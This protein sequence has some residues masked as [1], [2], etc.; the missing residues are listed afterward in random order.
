MPTDMVKV[1][2]FTLDEAL[3]L[4]KQ[5][6]TAMFKSGSKRTVGLLG[7]P[8]QQ[9][10]A[11]MNLRM[12]KPI[13]EYQYDPEASKRTVLEEA[14]AQPIRFQG[15][16]Y[17]SLTRF[18]EDFRERYGYSG[19]KY[20]SRYG[21]L[22]GPD[23][24]F[25]ILFNLN[26]PKIRRNDAMVTYQKRLAE[27]ARNVGKGL[28]NPNTGDPEKDAVLVQTG[29]ELVA[30][31][32][33]YKPRSNRWSPQ[34]IGELEMTLASSGV[35]SWDPRIE[36]AM[37]V[38]APSPATAGEI[39]VSALL[40]GPFAGVLTS[41]D[42][43][44]NL[45][46]D[47]LAKMG[48]AAQSS[49]LSPELVEE[50]DNPLDVVGKSFANTVRGLARIGVGFPV[51]V[52][53][54]VNSF[55]E[56]GRNV[57][58]GDF[59]SDENTWNGIDTTLINAIKDDYVQRYK[60]PFDTGLTS[61]ESWKKFGAEISKD[62]TAPALDILSVV[63]IIGW[64]AKGAGVA[65]TAAKVG[66]AGRFAD[67][68]PE[69]QARIARAEG[70]AEEFERLE[71]EAVAKIAGEPTERSW[72]RTDDAAVASYREGA[73]AA[74]DEIAR[75]VDDYT[76]AKTR[77]SAR[78]YNQ[79]AR[80]ALNGDVG[81][82]DELQILRAKGLLVPD[83]KESKIIRVGAKFEDK[84]VVL[85]RPRTL[86]E[87]TNGDKIAMRRLPASPILRGASQ[88]LMFVGRYIESKA[89]ESRLA[90]V[91]TEIPGVGY[92]WQYNRALNARLTADTYD[93][94]ES[95][96]ALGKS[97]VRVA[98]KAE[99]S[100]PV[101]RAALSLIRGGTGEFAVDHPMFERSLL[102]G[103]L[104]DLDSKVEIGDL[105]VEDVSAQR[106]ALQAKLD[107]VPAD[108]EYMTAMARLREK[109][110][111]PDSHP[112]DDELARAA[113][114]VDEGRWMNNRKERLITE[115]TDVLSLA[116]AKQ[117]FGEI[118]SALRLTIDDLF[119]A[120][121][122]FYNA[123]AR[124]LQMNGNYP[125]HS[126]RFNDRNSWQHVKDEQ[127]VTVYDK[128]DAEERAFLIDE[129]YRALD[130]AD[131]QGVLRDA[132]GSSASEGAP[133]M[134]LAKNPGK[135][136]RD[137]DFIAVHI[138]R[139]KGVVEAGKP[140]RGTIL[141]EDEVFVLPKE[142]F[143]RPK[144]VLKKDRARDLIEA[145]TL[146][147]L[148]EYFPNAKFYSDKVT[149]SG[150]SGESANFADL[151]WEGIVARNALKQHTLRM[152][153]LSQVQYV[154]NRFEREVGEI[155]EANAEL[156]PLN[157]LVGKRGADYKI[158]KH[159]R[160]F[161][162]R[163]AAER[164]AR[165]RGV[166]GEFAEGVRDVDSLPIMDSPFDIDAGFG[167]IERNGERL[168]VVR[169]DIRDWWR[170]AAEEEAS[171]LKNY[172]A[173]QRVMYEAFEDVPDSAGT[174]VL[175]VPNSVDRVAKRM[176]MEGNDFASNLL[177]RPLISGTT[178]VFKRL[179]L[180][181]N[182][183]FIG[184]NVI[185]GLAM[186]MLYNP[187][188]AGKVLTR[189]MQEAARRSGTEP[190]YNFVRDSGVLDYHLSYELNRNVYRQEMGKAATEDL[191]FAGMARK[192]GWNGGYTTIAAFERFVRKAVAKEF[193]DADPRFRQ[194]MAGEAVDEYIRRGVDFR[195]NPSDEI[196]RFEAAADLLLDPLSPY[197][198][199]RLKYRMRYTTN[200]V[201]GNYHTFGPAEQL[202]RNLLMPFYAWQRHSLAFTWR[203]PIDKPITALA[204][205]N[206]GGYGYNRM[207]EAGL[208]EWMYQTVPLPDFMKEALGLEGEDYRI[209]IG[210]ISPF[211]T[212][213]DM[214]LALQN[215]L[216]GSTSGSTILNFTN[217]YFNELIKTTTGVDPFT[218]R[219]VYERQG[220][221]RGLYNS[222]QSMPGIA[223]PKSLFWDSLS[224]A[225]EDDSLANRYRSI[226]NAEDILK[227]RDAD[228]RFSDWELSIPEQTTQIR[229][230]SW[231]DAA[232][233]AL[234]PLK[235]YEPNIARMEDL[236]Q[237]EAMA[238][239]VLRGEQ[240][241]YEKSEAERI[242]DN[243]REWQRKRDYVQGVWLPAAI[244]QGV[245]EA[246]IQLVLL[247]LED[248]KPKGSSSLSFN[249]VLS[250]LGG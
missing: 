92:R 128:V 46:R 125:L 109:L 139:L 45:A 196:T 203:L 193:L 50:N 188:V 36:Q 93:A 90:E 31:G 225:Y 88:G 18:Q 9:Y 147:A 230:G 57:L 111:D 66:R 231:Q 223:I 171:Q 95:Y 98:S 126:A 190:W 226:E 112:G 35:N 238:A 89:G 69:V 119:E 117:L 212:T 183:R 204:V 30:L 77:I 7:S 131:E 184:T 43:S 39:A 107:A 200:T 63:P 42:A 181:M 102:Q 177:N 240:N 54:V 160:V 115:E 32:Q 215:L 172:S 170:I 84:V 168:W 224:R 175:A 67:M 133:I 234:F 166:L 232:T 191:A 105:N 142:F 154:K 244:E 58:S 29:A 122:E 86:G 78:R 250:I 157:R 152:Y 165:D 6:Y 75:I 158:L 163:E 216:T 137:S 11:L 83:G 16:L 76:D 205:A 150:I 85:D 247:K 209:D 8:W 208:P 221:V 179:V 118:T 236:A 187:L 87:M 233:K 194:F 40:A 72:I 235:I 97:F 3:K 127:G 14:A 143:L 189:A 62:P 22:P 140:K 198:D 21:N 108:E 199:A 202:M 17:K 148:S 146:N 169:G 243:A 159:V 80:R 213:G 144:K 15:G 116:Y 201:S 59:E 1:P 60:T 173:Y 182:P 217:P 229:P 49:L 206:L 34:K 120:G 37:G 103:A 65:S 210:A 220:V 113:T 185:G 104:D 174:Y 192:Y 100:A 79:L 20:V 145:G 228:E 48:A 227:N 56:T 53:A 71:A 5:R 218:G 156:I 164:F 27:N 186:L 61:F 70:V 135:Y 94:V 195:G 129:L 151:A 13:P 24:K 4:S 101:E 25:A 153:A 106:A 110:A 249:R 242:V 23:S 136:G 214:G 114:L 33:E 55:G 41:N 141:N 96:T 222:F 197:Y 91:L 19:E 241:N 99:L 149:E 123:E 239:A 219:Q 237:E 248:E 161:S 81:A 155:L 180:N 68:T 245:D 2:K 12:G 38:A 51:G 52:A 207:L 121:G 47:A 178:N 10:Q 74:R 82:A 134:I 167:L 211:G 246:T 28:L 73:A 138:P 132:Q 64:A 162:D 130:A 44:S 176:V 26:D 124:V